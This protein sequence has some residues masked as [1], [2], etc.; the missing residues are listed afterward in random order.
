MWPI[1]FLVAGV[2][3][4]IYGIG[5][6]LDAR[7]AAHWPDTTARVVRADAQVVG[8]EKD[9]RTYA[10]DVA[11]TFAVEG[12]TY[13]GRRVTLVPR[14]YPQDFAVRAVLARYP[15]GGTARVFYDPRD[16]ANCVLDRS[17][18]GTEWAYPIGGVILVALGVYLWLQR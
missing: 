18:N 9:K 14:N 12:R 11:Y 10:P 13:E 16:P 4:L 1:V 15:V 7:N 5:L 17:T 6:V 8:R 2:A 3:V